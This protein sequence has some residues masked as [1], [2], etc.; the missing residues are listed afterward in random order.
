MSQDQ[1]IPPDEWDGLHFFICSGHEPIHN[2]DTKLG[3]LVGIPEQFNCSSFTELD[4]KDVYCG[5]QK[6]AID[7]ET[8]LG[9]DYASTMMLSSNAKAFGIAR[10]L[11]YTRTKH[12]YIDA[13]LKA[14]F[15][16]VAFTGWFFIQDMYG[17]RH[18]MNRIQ[19][20]SLF[21]FLAFTSAI[22]YFLVHDIVSCLRD[23][24]VDAKT[25]KLGRNY[26]EGGVE[27]YEKIL[28]RNRLLR[29]LLGRRGPK[30]FTYYGNQLATWRRPHVELTSRRDHMKK[31]LESYSKE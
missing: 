28:Q 11:N 2:G 10:E 30:V 17:M 21:G 9:A 24:A 26:A 25:G 22:V 23:N 7:W 16:G 4:R 1:A 14:F 13:G 18:R 12:L 3:A 8:K 5:N 15:T 20:A 27:F 29:E 6:L 19:K 31:R